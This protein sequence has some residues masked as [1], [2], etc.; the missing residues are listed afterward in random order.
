MSS[1]RSFPSSTSARASSV[2]TTNASW[3]NCDR[4]SKAVKPSCSRARRNSRFWRRCSKRSAG[5][6]CNCGRT[7]KLSTTGRHNRQHCTRLATWGSLLLL[8]WAQLPL[9]RATRCR[10]KPQRHGTPPT[11]SV[12]S[13]RRLSW[14][15]GIVLGNLPNSRVRRHGWRR[16]GNPNFRSAATLASARRTSARRHHRRRRPRAA[17]PGRLRLAQRVGLPQQGLRLRRPQECTCNVLRH[18]PHILRPPL[19][20]RGQA[21]LRR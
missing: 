10:R 18:L 6:T 9:V 8:Q 4:R 7:S 21:P 11:L 17:L 3:N 16:A 1:L 12:P 19:P 2:A 14:L 20:P 13:V 15:Q 5:T